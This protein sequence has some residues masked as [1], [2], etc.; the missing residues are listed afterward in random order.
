[1]CGPAALTA[2]AAAVTTMSKGVSMIS[3]MQAAA[4]QE[5][6]ARRN[7]ELEGD[8]ANDSLERGRVEQRRAQE[9]ASVRMGQIRA[10][11]AANG[12]DPSFGSAAVVQGD[13]AAAFAED[14]WTIGQNAMREAQGA[15]RRGANYRA[16]ANA[17]RAARGAAFVK[18]MFDM[19]SSVL[20]GVKQYGE[21]KK[22]WGR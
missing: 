22:A 19:A 8:A 17:A 21:E 14:S 4:Y 11:L 13:A 18:G 16:Q 15:D 7:A 10:A 1:M 3:S 6:V 5:K 20:G 2:A 9:A 12:I